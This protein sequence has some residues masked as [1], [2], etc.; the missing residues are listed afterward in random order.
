MAQIARNVSI[1]KTPLF[2]GVTHLL[3]D[4]DT[5]YTEQFETLL[6]D[7]GVEVVRTPAKCPRANGVAERFV[8]SVKHECLRKLILFGIGSL[9]R[10]LREYVD[11]HY[12]HER[13]HQGIGNKLIE[14]GAEVGLR[15]GKIVRVDRLG[16][17][18]R[19]YRRTA[20]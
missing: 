4:R 12:R 15:D 3:I 16:G 18:L 2:D 11:L 20:A 13:D 14:P 8:K 5:K 6:R 7:A 19:Y 17:L 1:E 9:E 10:A